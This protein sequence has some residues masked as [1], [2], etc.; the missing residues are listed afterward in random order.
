[1][2]CIKFS[3][4]HLR[5]HIDNTLQSIDGGNTI[6]IALFNGLVSLLTG[7]RLETPADDLRVKVSS[8]ISKPGGSGGLVKK[9]DNIWEIQYIKDLK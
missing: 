7:E 3:F 8:P 5:P 6:A 1:M 4:P 2:A 9:H